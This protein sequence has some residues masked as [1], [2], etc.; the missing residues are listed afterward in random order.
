[1]EINENWHL[2]DIVT[3]PTEIKLL[4][5]SGSKAY[6]RQIGSR[7]ICVREANGE[8]RGI[9]VK[10]LGRYDQERIIMIG[11]EP[12]SKDDR[13]ELFTGCRY[14][15]YPFPSASQ[16]KEVLDIIGN[17]KP[18][19]K[20]FEEASMH[21]NPNAKFWVSE[22]ASRLLVMKRAQCYDAHTGLLC[23]PT[24]DDSPYRLTTVYFY[25]GNLIW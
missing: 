25:K 20:L 17:N 4:K 8:Q 12:F 11:G 6:E 15:S 24:G 14:F 22:T 19:L 10:V 18:L 16:V 7:Y 3:L 21:V 2:G 9:L 1:M 13:E 5:K 23:N